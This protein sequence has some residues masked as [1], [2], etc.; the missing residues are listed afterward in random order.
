MIVHVPVYNTPKYTDICIAICF[1]RPIHYQKPVENLKIFLNDLQRSN[2]PVFSIELL[3][4]DQQPILP[5]PTKVVRSNSVIF[6]KENLWNIL[7]KYIPS[8]Y[9]KIIFLDTDIRFTDPDWFN[10]S[11]EL[12]NTYKVFQPMDYCYR[13]IHGEQDSYE[14]KQNKIRPTMSKGITLK[15][16]INIAQHYPGF[17]IV[18]DRNFF[19]QINGIFDRGLNGYGDSLFWG[20]F[21]KFSC[22][23]IY[24]ASKKCKYYQQYQKNIFDIISNQ[25]NITT[26]IANNMCLHLYHGSEHNRRYDRRENYI[27]QSYE[28]YYN[29]DGVLEMN[30]EKDLRQY[31]IDR[32]EDE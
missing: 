29:E 17:G 10:K 4:N 26:F 31:W 15:E 25:S 5:N 19:H 32:K 30:A 3:Y 13:D 22:K 1:F 18:I 27:P 20:C 2:L 8:Q 11:S 7:E 12:L 14:L 16:S 24:M 23:Y 9:S 6:S 28:L 21:D